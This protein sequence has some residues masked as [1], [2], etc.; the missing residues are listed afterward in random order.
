MSVFNGN[1]DPTDWLQEKSLLALQ[2][3]AKLVDLAN[4]PDTTSWYSKRLKN[5]AISMIGRL[6]PMV[7]LLHQADENAAK[8]TEWQSISERGSIALAGWVKKWDITNPNVFTNSLL[9]EDRSEEEFNEK[10]TPM[11]EP[12]SEAG[13]DYRDAEKVEIYGSMMTTL[14]HSELGENAKNLLIWL[15]YNL[16]RSDYSDVTIISKKF[17]PTDCGLSVIETERAYE[18]LYRRGYILKVRN[19]EGL[20]SDALVLKLMVSGLN[21]NN[22]H[23]TPM[24]KEVFGYEGARIGGKVT[25]GNILVIRPP[26]ALFESIARWGINGEALESIKM[27]LQSK[28]GEDQIYIETITLDTNDKDKFFNIKVRQVFAGDTKELTA[29]M[30]F[31]LVDILKTHLQNSLT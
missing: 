5:H 6:A 28:I 25:H 2:E 24:E 27:D 18:E 9:A 22:K 29:A 4:E 17:L 23:P 19:L 30:E 8:L 13:S 21:D 1:F 20:A 16:R 3:A 10:N 31:A 7:V 12:L 11:E 26:T 15:L 14:M